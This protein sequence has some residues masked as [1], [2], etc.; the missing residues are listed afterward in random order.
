MWILVTRNYYA[1]TM[2]FP[3]SP[4][5]LTSPDVRK[6]TKNR[7]GQEPFGGTLGDNDAKF[8]AFWRN[9]L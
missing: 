1:R 5:V 2:S 9:D 3:L 6:S 8:E 7:T 4:I